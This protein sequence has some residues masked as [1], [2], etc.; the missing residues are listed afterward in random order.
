MCW[1]ELRAAAFIPCVTA[2]PA[3][4]LCYFLVEGTR[5]WVRGMQPRALERPAGER[6]LVAPA[7]AG[8][9]RPGRRSCAHCTDCLL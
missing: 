4:E 3:A 1:R 6:G 9:D 8:G 5:V 7:D 2:V